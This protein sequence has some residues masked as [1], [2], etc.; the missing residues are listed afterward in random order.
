L[1]GFPRTIDQA[2]ELDAVLC[3]SGHR[4]DAA[5]ALRVDDE[6]IIGRL[7]GRR[8]CRDC[9]APWHVEFYPTEQ[10]GV[11][12][13]CGGELYQR[14]D[15]TAKTIRARLRTYHE[16]TAPLVAFYAED[17]RLIEVAAVGAVDD[18][19]AAIARALAPVLDRPKVT[20]AARWPW[21]GGSLWFAEPGR[22]LVGG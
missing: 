8:T 5:L 16:H 2:R 22:Q 9:G 17:D 1:D 20:I 14:E 4:L 21:T 15:D 12:D 11:C 19:A 3:G 6:E 18:V 10:D 13:S 7:S